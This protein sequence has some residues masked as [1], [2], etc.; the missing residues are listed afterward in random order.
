MYLTFLPV[1][2]N[3]EP[4]QQKNLS[5]VFSFLVT[6]LF[7]SKGQGGGWVEIRET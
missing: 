5:V 3:M 7:L 2:I 1:W 6:P 4:V